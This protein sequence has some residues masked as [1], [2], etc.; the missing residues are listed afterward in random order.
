VKFKILV[1]CNLLVLAS[2]SVEVYGEIAKGFEG[3]KTHHGIVLYML[4]EL[5]IRIKEAVEASKGIRE[6]KETF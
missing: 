1:T 6:V 3:I 4:A 5:V 2:C